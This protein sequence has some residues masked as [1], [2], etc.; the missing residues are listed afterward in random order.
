MISNPSSGDLG[1][2]WS[3]LDPSWGDLGP[4]EGPRWKKTL[5]GWLENIAGTGGPR[6]VFNVLESN[7]RRPAPELLGSGRRIVT[8]PRPRLGPRG[9]AGLR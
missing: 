5:L 4:E 1:A 6:N 7:L 9:L 3:D 8:A 2:S